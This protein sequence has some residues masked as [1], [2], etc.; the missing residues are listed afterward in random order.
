MPRKPKKIQG[1]CDDCGKKLMIPSW[2]RCADCD[3]MIYRKSYFDKLE[4]KQF[5][6]K[7]LNSKYKNASTLLIDETGKIIGYKLTK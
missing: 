4:R 1:I 2:L 7:N 3:F 5:K 6:F